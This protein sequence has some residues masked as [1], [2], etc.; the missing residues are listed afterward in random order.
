MTDEQQEASAERTNLERAAAIRDGSIDFSRY[1]LEQLN[2]LRFV[3]NENAFPLNCA[4][5][6]AELERRDPLQSSPKSLESSLAPRELP[7]AAGKVRFTAHDGLRGWLQAKSRRLPLYGEGFVE[8]RSQELVLG[9]W[10]RSWL[11]IGQRTEVFVPLHTISD[12]IQGDGGSLENGREGDWVRLRY[13]TAL[14][15]YQFVEF[16][17]GSA[18]QASTLIEA[19]PKAR[20]DGYEHWTAV[21]EFDARLR[22]AGGRPWIT[23]AIVIAN[24]AVFVATAL[25]LKHLNLAEAPEMISWGANFAPLTLHGQWW[26]LFS[27]LFLHANIAHVFFNMWALWNV[28]RLTERLYGNWAFGFLY[29]ACGVLSGLASIAWDPSRATL[30]ASGAIFGIFAAFIVF[31]LHPHGRIAVK[32]PRALWISTLVFALYNLV[33]GLFATSID[34]AAHVGGVISGLVLGTC[35]VRPLTPSVRRQFPLRNVIAVAALTAVG[36]LAALWQAT[37]IGDQPTAPE[38]YMRTHLWYANGEAVNLRKWQEIMV[39][40]GSG[41]LSNAAVGERF[42][43]EIVPFWEATSA[44]LKSEDASLPG[45]ERQYGSLLADYSRLRLEWARALVD[46]A[47]GNSD[48]A[49]DVTRYE[50]DSNLAVARI[51]RVALLASLDHRPRAL[52]NSPWIVATTNWFVAWHWQCVVPPSTPGRLPSQGDSP[53]DGPAARQAAACRAQ[54]L[55]IS[56]DYATLDRWMRQA[57]ESMKDLPDGGSTFDGIVRGLTDLF[58]YK[59][60]DVVQTLGRTADWRRRAPDSVY[61]AL[62]QSLVFESWAWTARGQGYANSISPQAWLVFAQRTEMAAMGLQEIGARAANNPALV[63]ALAQRWFGPVEDGRRAG[64]D[65]PTRHRS[66]AELLASVYENAP[67]PH[68]SL[69]WQPGRHQTLY[70]AILHPGRRSERLRKVCAAVLEL[71]V[72]GGR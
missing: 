72:A 66:R 46:A 28:G 40:A 5:L 19:L 71:L 52:V 6:V 9:G 2:E 64:L 44:R 13:E 29:F 50:R 69:A 49:T 11:G 26:R 21:R 41:Q 23:P 7:L 59:P 15:H 51:E 33:T 38:R 63:P 25:A 20:S 42:G 57:R 3:L 37:G 34:N 48:R 62:I 10:Q 17:A 22:E 43:R 36:V 61:P 45:D 58:G 12:V 56:S 55:F 47:G 24:V 32:V 54:K 68:A 1:S 4:N 60:L 18:Q 35:L 16:Q 70:L 8:I 65:I 31:A 30:G 39:E 27:A 53:T 14:G 67:H